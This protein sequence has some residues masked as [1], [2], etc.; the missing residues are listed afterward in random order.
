MRGVLCANPTRPRRSSRNN[1]ALAVE[2]LVQVLNCRWRDLRRSNF[3]GYVIGGPLG[4]DQLHHRFAPSGG[5]SRGGLVVRIAA[6]ANQRGVAHAPRSLVQRAS[7]GSSRRDVAVA[8]E[9]KR[10]HGVM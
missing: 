8:V 3:G 2:A 4:E 5:G 1:S 9:R 6:A 10:A 7:G